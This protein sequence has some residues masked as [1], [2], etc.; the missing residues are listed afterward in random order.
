M[1]IPLPASLPLRRNTAFRLLWAAQTVS[2]YGSLI[3][4]SALRFTAVLLLKASPLQMALLEM[5]DLLPRLLIGLAVGVWV[6]RVRRRPVL[7]AADVGRALI[8][9]LVPLAAFLGLLRMELL[10]VVTCLAGMFTL[11]FDVAHR[12]Y[13]PSV[14]PRGQLLEANSRISATCALSEVG[15]FAS[16]GWLVQLFSAPLAILIDSVTFVVSALLLGGIH[17]KEAPPAAPE[18]D[19]AHSPLAEGLRTVWHHPWLRVFAE[20]TLLFDL[21]TRAFGTVFLIYVMRDLHFQPGVLGMIWAVGGVS[22]FFGASLAERVTRRV[23]MGNALWGGL[24]LFACSMLLIP[25]AQGTGWF[26]IGCMVAQQFG[27]GFYVVYD[28]NQGSLRQAA[29]PSALLGRVDA[30]LRTVSL[31]AMLLG[32]LLGGLSGQWLGAR[33]TLV[34]AGAGA[35]LAALRLALSPLRAVRDLPPAAD[36]AL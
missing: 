8:V 2:A 9:A 27:D 31:I 32:S 24:A 36:D 10:Y 34:L 3:T 26:A 12:A 5:A 30:N 14:V 17:V 25:A 35:L 4:G 33:A 19:A 20:S 16:A 7:I 23:G 28:V 22:S 21:A 13:V 18:P 15:G 11:L 6:D 1:S 29:V